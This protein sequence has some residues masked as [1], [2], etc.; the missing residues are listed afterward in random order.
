MK[1]FLF[2]IIPVFVLIVY[3]MTSNKNL[4]NILGEK[5]IGNSINIVY[6][7]NDLGFVLEQDSKKNNISYLKNGKVVGE[8]VF[9]VGGMDV[10]N[11][12]SN[13]LGMMIT[14]KYWVEN[15]YIIEGVSSLVKYSLVDRRDN[16]QIAVCENQITVGS[17]II[18]GSY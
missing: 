11:F 4:I 8:C 6:S 1:K 17:P 2:V 15:K 18:Y 3:L 16:V 7:S 5:N 10:V 12:V 9:L 14:K 13:K